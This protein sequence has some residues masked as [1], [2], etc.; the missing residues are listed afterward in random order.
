MTPITPPSMSFTFSLPDL[1]YIARLIEHEKERW[2]ALTFRYRRNASWVELLCRQLG[3]HPPTIDYYSE[4]G[5]DLDVLEET[6]AVHGILIAAL[7]AK[8]ARKGLSILGCDLG[9]SVRVDA[10]T[11]VGC[12]EEQE[13]RMKL[14]FEKMRWSSWKF[15]VGE[16]VVWQDEVE[17]YRK[18]GDVISVVK[19]EKDKQ[20]E[21]GQDDLQ[22]DEDDADGEHDEEDD[23]DHIYEEEESEVDYDEEQEDDWGDEPEPEHGLGLGLRLGYEDASEDEDEQEDEEHEDEGDESEA[24]DFEQVPSITNIV[25]LE[26]LAIDYDTQLD[27]NSDSDRMRGIL[28]HRRTKSGWEDSLVPFV[29]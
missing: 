11:R 13:R 3:F 16:L 29:R 8:R 24:E 19:E 22:D 7:N 10:G 26:E 4:Y 14:Q 9:G 20:E 17:G 27:Y 2:N 23:E 28:Y 15:L 25:N 1:G 18:D 6:K 21:G 12:V 5:L